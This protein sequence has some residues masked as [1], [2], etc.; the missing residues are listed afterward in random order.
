M[1]LSLSHA[2]PT[3]LAQPSRVT[4]SEERFEPQ[5]VTAETKLTPAQPLVA[6]GQAVANPLFSHKSYI[7][8][9]RITTSDDM[10]RLTSLCSIHGVGLIVFTLGSGLVDQSQKMTVAASAMAEK[11]TVGHRS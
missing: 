5:I 1:G 9:P 2:I 4:L 6:F 3:L 8:V 10:N 7:V 11:K